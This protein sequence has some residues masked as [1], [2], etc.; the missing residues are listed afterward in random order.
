MEFKKFGYWVSKS[1]PKGLQNGTK[2]ILG[3][4]KKGPKTATQSMAQGLDLAMTV[5]AVF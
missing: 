2:I 5:R 4:I 3:E 1:S